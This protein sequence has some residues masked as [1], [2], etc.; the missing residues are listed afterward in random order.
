MTHLCWMVHVPWSLTSHVY[1]TGKGLKSIILR[2]IHTYIH[3][4]VFIFHVINLWVC[5]GGPFESELHMYFAYERLWTGPLTQ[6]YE[7]REECCFRQVCGYI[8]MQTYIL[9]NM[10]LYKY[11]RIFT[12]A[13][14]CCGYSSLA[15]FLFYSRYDF[16]A[17][18]CASVFV[19]VW[20]D[21]VSTGSF[22]VWVLYVYIGICL[23]ASLQATWRAYGSERLL[24]YIT[25][26]H[27]Y[28]KFDNRK[29]NAP[30]LL[31]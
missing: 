17:C 30:Q 26:V 5:W 19:N 15:A 18:A 1:I 4:I 25:Y 10:Y 2:Y 11:I 31:E 7:V 29:N 14:F 6:I 21:Y 16:H 28:M 24:K 13:K 12:A 20:M 23:E 3:I 27:T 9:I 8:Y 22:I